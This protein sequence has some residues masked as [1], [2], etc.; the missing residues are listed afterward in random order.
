MLGGLPRALKEKNLSDTG[1]PRRQGHQKTGVDPKL[2]IRRSCWTPK[3][4][5]GYDAQGPK[6]L[7]TARG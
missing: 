5:S 7:Q 6:G 2:A 1:W 4:P 3:W